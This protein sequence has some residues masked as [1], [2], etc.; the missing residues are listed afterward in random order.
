MNIIFEQIGALIKVYSNRQN[1]I[2][3]NIIQNRNFSG[4]VLV[5]VILKRYQHRRNILW[6]SGEGQARIGKGWPLRPKAWK[7]KPEPRAYI[8]V[9]CHPPTTT[10]TTHPL[11]SLMSRLYSVKTNIFQN[12]FFWDFFI[13]N[14]LSRVD[15]IIKMVLEFLS[16]L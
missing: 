11:V 8:K 7:L 10:T 1:G 16:N 5:F 13:R 3:A 6:S 2:A 4:N 12:A 14:D 15:L 9:S